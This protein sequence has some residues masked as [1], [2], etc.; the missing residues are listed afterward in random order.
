MKE[1]FFNLSDNMGF[2][3]YVPFVSQ[4][5]SPVKIPQD[6]LYQNII[7]AQMYGKDCYK[8]VFSSI[9]TLHPN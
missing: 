2:W 3:L 8:I 4:K 6:E 5:S 7:N 1:T 9:D